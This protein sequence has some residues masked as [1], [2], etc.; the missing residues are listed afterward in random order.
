MRCFSAQKKPKPVKGI[1]VNYRITIETRAGVNYL[2]ENEILQLMDK[3]LYSMT[4]ELPKDLEQYM[5][6]FLTRHFDEEKGRKKSW[7]IPG[8]SVDKTRTSYTDAGKSTVATASRIDTG[9]RTESQKLT[10]NGRD[11][12]YYSTE[13]SRDRLD[14]WE[15]M[16]M[17]KRNRKSKYNS[18]KRR[19]SDWTGSVGALGGDRLGSH[20]QER[21]MTQSSSSDSFRLHSQSRRS[22]KKRSTD[23]MVAS[24][25]VTSKRPRN[26]PR[27]KI[28]HERDSDIS[29]KESNQ[30]NRGSLLRDSFSGLSEISS[31]SASN[32]TTPRQRNIGIS[33]GRYQEGRN[34]LLRTQITEVSD[35]SPRSDESSMRQE[36]RGEHLIEMKKRMNEVETSIDSV[37]MM[38][39]R[40]AA[41]PRDRLK[42]TNRK[43]QGTKVRRSSILAS[44]LKSRHRELKNIEDEAEEFIRNHDMLEEERSGV[45]PELKPQRRRGSTVSLEMGQNISEYLSQRL[46][47]TTTNASTKHIDET[48]FQFQDSTN[49]TETHTENGHNQT[50]NTLEANRYDKKRDVTDDS[51][52]D[53]V[54]YR[55]TSPGPSTTTALVSNS[56]VGSRSV[57]NTL[58]ST[59]KKRQTLDRSFTQAGDQMGGNSKHRSHT[60]SSHNNHHSPHGSKVRHSCNDLPT[61]SHR[62]RD[63]MLDSDEDESGHESLMRDM[64]DYLAR[65]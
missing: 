6:E 26:L 46:A 21:D 22:P 48:K 50:N 45:S 31:A 64:K 8:K 10:R 23:F 20:W 56:S 47:K 58:G 5:L 41:N 55:N 32:M 16:E 38:E 25:V 53:V 63:E 52:S 4:R 40:S 54:N 14:S 18:E 42:Y 39:T 17:K 37:A 24:P 28:N 62:L 30:P 33:N 49:A 13:I 3:L 7:A 35:P 60:K 57:Q 36:R 43:I 12:G 29:S 51:Y 15:A 27:T 1:I 44:P 59:T 2:F 9:Y 34:N 61:S 11:D 19:H 65:H